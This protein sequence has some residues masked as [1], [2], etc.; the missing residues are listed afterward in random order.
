M[1]YGCQKNVMTFKNNITQC[2]VKINV[3]D[4]CNSVPL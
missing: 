1:F 4:G 3:A 2:T